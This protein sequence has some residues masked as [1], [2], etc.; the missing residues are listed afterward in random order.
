MSAP[1]TLS[2]PSAKRSLGH[3]ALHYKQPH[4]GPLAARLLRLLGLTETQVLQLSDGTHFY[5]FVVDPANAP[6]GDGIIY[7]SAMPPAQRAVLEA[8]HDALKIGK[9]GE[10][11]AAA[12][13]R[14]A[15]GADPEYTFHVG[16]LV[17]SLEALESTVLE[18]Q[19]L[20]QTDPELKGRLKVVL[21]RPLPGTVQVDARLDASPLFSKV[22]RHAYGRNGVQAFIETDL[23]GSGPLGENLVIELDY[24]FPGY[25]RHILSVVE[26]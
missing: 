26:L 11:P 23:L 21:N 19:R 8:V 12:Q 9:E 16:V 17:A 4:E 5:R 3:I 22:T 18:V 25:D 20:G 1:T 2:R 6:G 10:H 24:L 7:L 15:Q 14:A 13:L